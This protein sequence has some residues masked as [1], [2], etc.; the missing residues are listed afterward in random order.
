VVL[1]SSLRREDSPA[2]LA[3]LQDLRDAQGH[4]AQFF[5]H[6]L[7]GAPHSRINVHEHRLAANCKASV[8]HC[9]QDELRNHQGKRKKETTQALSK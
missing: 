7:L 9:G 4:R 3:P 5:P 2:T 8:T 6:H 1:E